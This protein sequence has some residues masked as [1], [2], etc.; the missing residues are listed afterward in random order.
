[1]ATVHA[2]RSEGWFVGDDLPLPGGVSAD[3]VLV[4]PAG[5]LVVQCMRSDQVAGADAAGRPAPVRARIA[6]QRLRHELA[7]RELA[8]EVV[9]TVL[10]GGPGQ[11]EVPGGV[12]VIDGVA[13]LFED[14]AEEWLAHLLSRRLL[15]DRVV[16]AVREVVGGLLE[17]APVTVP[18]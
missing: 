10:A 13:Y 9:P 3:H 4:G 15:D 5:V 18:A 7:V 2:L 17:L 12:K 1:M 11:P 14:A 6:A 8:V 16:D